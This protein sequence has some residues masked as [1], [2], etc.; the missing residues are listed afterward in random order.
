MIEDMADQL[1]KSHDI[2]E[3]SHVALP[4]QEEVTVVGR[5]C[6]DSNGKLNAK[7]VLL[8]G[9]VDMSSGKT[10]PV[11]LSQLK[12]F[13]LFPGQVCVR[14]AVGIFV[15][16]LYYLHGQMHYFENIMS[17]NILRFANYETSW[18]GLYSVALYTHVYGIKKNNI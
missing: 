7:S 13:A 10:I 11:D 15:I 18:M 1:K 5:I 16:S 3:F 2:E 6:C 4:T 17:D 9:S 14:G 8:E 12:E